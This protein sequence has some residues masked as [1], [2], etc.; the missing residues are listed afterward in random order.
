MPQA[1]FCPAVNLFLLNI[2]LVCICRSSS[3]RPG[4]FGYGKVPFSLPLHRPNRQAR[5]TG[6]NTDGVLGLTATDD[7]TENIRKDEE[8]R[9]RDEEDGEA[10]RTEE[11]EQ[12]NSEAA[13]AEEDP[14]TSSPRQHVDRPSHTPT[15]HGRSRVSSRYPFSRSPLPSVFTNRQ[16]FDWNSVTAPPPPMPSLS[17]LRSPG[18]SPPFSSPLHRPGPVLRDREL[19]PGFGP[20][21]PPAGNIYPLQHPGPESGRH[22]RVAFRCSGPEKEYRRCF[23]QVGLHCS[24]ILNA[25]EK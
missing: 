3:I 19:H 6:N 22:G 15:E 7:N 8:Q 9:R 21:T 5:H 10:W 25:L 11:E 4:Q 20:Q 16:R 24:L 17:R 1:F 2:L 23:S 13:P 12:A 18:G 14:T